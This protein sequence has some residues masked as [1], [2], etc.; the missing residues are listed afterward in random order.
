[1]ETE[2]TRRAERDYLN[3]SPQRQRQVDKP[4]DYLRNDLHHPSLR[5]K[6]YGG[7]DDVWQGRVNRDCRF[8]FQIVGDT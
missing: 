6:K 4:F 5:A 7:A 3:L 2:L 1:M 8:Y